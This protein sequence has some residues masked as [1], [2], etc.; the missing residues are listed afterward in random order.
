MNS[1]REICQDLLNGWSSWTLTLR[2][3]TV[4]ICGTA[5]S[6]S[7]TTGVSWSTTTGTSHRFDFVFAEKTVLVAINPDHQWLHSLGQFIFTDFAILVF[8]KSHQAACS[9]HR[10]T[11]GS[12]AFCTP[13]LRAAAVSSTS[14][15]R[16]SC[17]A[18]ASTKLRLQLIGSQFSVFVSIK[19]LESLCG[20]IDFSCRDFAITIGIQCYEHR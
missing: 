18:S 13:T 15:S 19:S 14:I 5:T 6:W 1:E 17:S 7:T 2:A 3:G 9:I 10:S 20:V 16:S 11:A 12:T 8:I 4:S